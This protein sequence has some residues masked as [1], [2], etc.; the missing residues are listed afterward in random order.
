MTKKYN[1]PCLI[2]DSDIHELFKMFAWNTIY[3]CTETP[4]PQRTLKCKWIF[5]II[6]QLKPQQVVGVNFHIK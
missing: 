4:P 5:A 6:K 2:L 1:F 3:F